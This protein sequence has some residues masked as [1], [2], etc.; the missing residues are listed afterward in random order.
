MRPASTAARVSHEGPVSPG[1]GARA[2]LLLLRGY[3]LALSPLF[4]GSC[5]YSPSCSE[6]MR[7]AIHEYGLTMRG[8]ARR[9]TPR[10]LSSL[11]RARIRSRAAPIPALIIHGKTR[12]PRSLALARR[13]P[14]VSVAHAGAEAAGR[15]SDRPGGGILGIRACD[16]A[17]AGP[18]VPAMAPQDTTGSGVTQPLPASVT[19]ES[20]QRSIVVETSTVI[21][22]FDNRGG[23]VTSWRLKHYKDHTGQL[24]DIIPAG[25]P[26]T[27]SRPF[28]FKADDPGDDGTAQPGSVSR[29]RERTRDGRPR[30]GQRAHPSHLRVRRCAGLD[31]HEDVR[32]RT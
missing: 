8:V 7:I 30:R 18:A 19:S 12:A 3:K 31:R 4:A 13:R 22:S 28:E 15:A 5:R 10:P 27:E 29:A 32:V 1:P 6:F 17:A 11:R 14:G 9:E 23:E 21:A 25:V 20:A 2:A 26:P 24:V 16:D